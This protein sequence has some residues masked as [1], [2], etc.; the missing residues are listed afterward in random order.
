MQIKFIT[1]TQ[2]LISQTAHSWWT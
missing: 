1:L 2:Q